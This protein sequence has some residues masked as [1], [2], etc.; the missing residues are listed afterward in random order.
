MQLYLSCS[1]SLLLLIIKSS[2]S[3]PFNFWIKAFLATFFSWSAR[4]WVINFLLLALLSGSNFD[5]ANYIAGFYE[6]FLIF[7]RQLVMWIMMLVMPTPGGSGFAEAVFSEY[8][9]EFIPAGFVAI[10][11]LMWRLVTYYP[12]L[13]M[14]VLVLPKWVKKIVNKK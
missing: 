4:Y 1:K 5:A 2:L 6:H 8:M 7:A 3:K 14:G 9:A 13:L 11:A 12:Y 10:M